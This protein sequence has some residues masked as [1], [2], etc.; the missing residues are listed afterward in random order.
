MPDL[1]DCVKKQETKITSRNGFKL[2]IEGKLI[3]E[4]K[5]LNLLVAALIFFYN[6]KGTL[7]R[8]TFPV[9]SHRLDNE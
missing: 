9:I 7:V 4:N 1:A 8:S 3:V 2:T 6:R 5:G